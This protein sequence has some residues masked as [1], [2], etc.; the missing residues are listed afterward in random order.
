MK[1]KNSRYRIFIFLFLSSLVMSCEKENTNQPDQPE[2]KLQ[3]FVP[4]DFNTIQAAIDAS[5]D[6]DKIIVMPG[7]YFENIDFK[8]KKCTCAKYFS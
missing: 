6:G 3:I 1:I 7:I 2:D 4:I 5:S 8:G